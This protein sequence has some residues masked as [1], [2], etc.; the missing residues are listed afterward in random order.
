MAVSLEISISQSL[1]LFIWELSHRLA[2]ALLTSGDFYLLFYNKPEDGHLLTPDGGGGVFVNTTAWYS[3]PHN[4][5]REVCESIATQGEDGFIDLWNYLWDCTLLD[6]VA[7]ET[8][9]T[10]PTVV[11][12]LIPTA[13]PTEVFTPELSL[14][15]NHGQPLDEVK[16]KG[17]GFPPNKP[18]KLSWDG[19]GGEHLS[20]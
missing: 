4:T 1:A 9:T 8:P 14:D 20:R 15:P 19:P 18:V 11:P 5:A 10:A 2:D 13:T 7:V 6:S 17:I 3:G 12:T 16:A